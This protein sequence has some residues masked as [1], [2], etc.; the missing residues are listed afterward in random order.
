MGLDKKIPL[1][2]VNED[3]LCPKLSGDIDTFLA[4]DGTWLAVGVVTPPE[5]LSIDASDAGLGLG[6]NNG[7]KITMTFNKATNE[8]AVTTIAELNTIFTWGVGDSLGTTAFGTWISPSE[9]EITISDVTGATIAEGDII[10][11]KVGGNLKNA[12]N[13]SDPS[14]D[15]MVL[16][17]SFGAGTGLYANRVRQKQMV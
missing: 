7:D 16:G 13:T 17:G 12:A 6:L 15:S 8:P 11:I 3:G 2:N 4:G 9:L 10:T 1:V 14:I 5:F